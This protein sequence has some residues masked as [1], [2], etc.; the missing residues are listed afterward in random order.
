MKLKNKAIT[1]FIGFISAITLF[2]SNSFAATGTV[3][4]ETVRMREEP[5]TKASI[6]LNLDKDDEVDII[7]ESDGWYKVEF[8]GKSG[9]VS[10]NYLDVK[11]DIASSTS[12][13]NTL[14][15]NTTLK[16]TNTISEETEST[17]INED[18]KN[19]IDESNDIKIEVDKEYIVNKNASIYIL[20]LVSSIKLFYINEKNKGIVK[21]V[22]NLWV[23]VSC[24]SGNGW[25]IKDVLNNNEKINNSEKSSDNEKI[26]SENNEKK[27][28]T[29]VSS[30]ENKIGYVNFE[31]VYL[32]KGASTD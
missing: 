21:E 3:T 10:A 15:N 27:T 22:T 4:A 28:E 6:V 13:E 9:Y 24:E 5:T 14:N 26:S 12:Y 30:S 25:I 11:G 20:P 1:F 19:N 31:I 32:R 8:E 23:Y 2:I 29:N 7:E 16:D 18:E 17:N